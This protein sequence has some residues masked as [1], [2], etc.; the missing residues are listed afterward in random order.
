VRY[1][2]P[3]H[4][5]FPISTCPFVV[6]LPFFGSPAIGSETLDGAQRAFSERPS[7]SAFSTPSNCWESEPRHWSVPS[8]FLCWCGVF[9]CGV[10]SCCTFIVDRL[11][12]LSSLA[13]H[14]RRHSSLSSFP[15]AGD[16]M[17]SSSPI[18][19]GR[20]LFIVPLACMCS[21]RMVGARRVPTTERGVGDRDDRLH[22][23]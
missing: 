14:A 4:P 19:R 5:L 16:G 15:P 18:F 6:W 8:P 11:D 3:R 13:R 21:A 17:P 12:E 10:G 22:L 7:V 9:L 20:P 23:A 1:H 2:C